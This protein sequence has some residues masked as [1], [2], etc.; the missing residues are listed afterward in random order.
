MG[1]KDHRGVANFDPQGYGWQDLC[2]G[3]LGIATY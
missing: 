3:P 1:A 2:R